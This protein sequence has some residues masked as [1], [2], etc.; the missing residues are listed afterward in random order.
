MTSRRHIEK[1][2][3]FYTLFN[4]Y[5]D[6]NKTNIGRKT[7]ANPHGNKSETCSTRLEHQ[8]NY[9]NVLTNSRIENGVYYNL[10]D[11]CS[12]RNQLSTN[13]IPFLEPQHGLLQLQEED[14]IPIN[15]FPVNTRDFGRKKIK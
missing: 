9:Q 3:T 15:G 2:T 11:Q 10:K 12:F 8:F 5:Q 7:Y 4:T 6:Y 14:K 13:C 1:D